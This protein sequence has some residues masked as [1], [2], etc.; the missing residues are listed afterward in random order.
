MVAVEEHKFEPGCVVFNEHVN[1]RML[2]KPAHVMR[3]IVPVRTARVILDDAGVFP[4]EGVLQRVELLLRIDGRPVHRARVVRALDFIKRRTLPNRGVFGHAKP[5]VS[6]RAMSS[7]DDLVSVREALMADA[8]RISHVGSWVWNV[9]DQAVHWSDNLYRLFG[10]EPKS[11]V[12][13]VETFFEMVHPDDRAWVKAESEEIAV[14]GGEPESRYRILRADGVARLFLAQAR[15]VRDNEG[16]LLRMIGVFT[17]LTHRSEYETELERAKH[18]LDDAQRVANVGS[19]TWNSE[20]R[21][22]TWSDQLRRMGGFADDEEA[23]RSRLIALLHPR[24]REETVMKLEQCLKSECVSPVESRLL[25]PDESVRSVAIQVRRHGAAVTGVVHDVTERR[26]LEEQLRWATALESTGRLAAGIAHDFNNLLTV[27]TLSAES[28]Q[29]QPSPRAIE[30]I[31]AAA[32]S[33]AAL[34]RGLL[35]FARTGEGNGVLE[36]CSTVS[37]GAAWMERVSGDEISVSLS[38]PKHP[39]YVRGIAAEIQQV[40]LNLT[41]NAKDAMP[42][43][44][45][46]S[47]RIDE[48]HQSRVT[49]VFADDGL[50]MDAETR[51]RAFDAFFSTKA[52]DNRGTG[53]GLSMV[54]GV[55]TR[56]GGSVSLHSELGEGTR[57]LIELPRASVPRARDTASVESTP[58]R[59]GVV[60][61]VEDDPAVLRGTARVL[62][63][64]GH[65]VLKASGPLEAIRILEGTRVD[66]ILSDVSMPNGSGPRVAEDAQSLQPNVP[67]LFMSGHARSAEEPPG[68]LLAK[69]FS[70]SQLLEAVAALLAKE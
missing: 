23:S 57:V 36:L 42:S 6:L 17:D 13:T 60:L 49:L 25:L 38:L 39:V 15:A 1:V 21:T 61:V 5:V 54:Y 69:P 2:S 30:E 58:A 50:G 3:V 41:T 48:T 29:L 34:V 51:E 12:P 9:R 26:Q 44:G 59:L 64:A 11:F 19:F 10:F 45:E 20:T 47:I 63:D 7:H 32:N 35:A 40:L 67:M 66:L 70:P 55:V 14:N 56:L 28:A 22:T 53:L 33:G 27:I 52:A 16:E 46:I 68:E 8:E 37:D 62:A 4:A 24:E 65:S 43:G 31:I 18:S